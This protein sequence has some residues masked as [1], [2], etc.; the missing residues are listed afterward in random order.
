MPKLLNKR[1]CT[2]MQ[3]AHAV[4]IGRGSKWGNPWSH[5]PSSTATYH[6]ATRAEAVAAH[7]DWFLHSPEAEGLRADARAELRGKDLL[8]YCAP[9]ECHGTVLMEY[10]NE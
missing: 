6:V 8:C 3:R 5:L 10:A 2:Y 1:R 9:A 4:Y 7:R